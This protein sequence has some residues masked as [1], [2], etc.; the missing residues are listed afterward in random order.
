MSLRSYNVQ[1][2][3]ADY[4]LIFEKLSKMHNIPV[5][6]IRKVYLAQGKTVKDSMKNGKLVNIVVPMI[7]QFEVMYRK[8]IA[9]HHKGKLEIRGNQIVRREATYA[10]KQKGIKEIV[11]DI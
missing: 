4:E 11:Y 2:S 3:E 5:S 9:Y 7:G 6:E 1:P 10:L 8:V